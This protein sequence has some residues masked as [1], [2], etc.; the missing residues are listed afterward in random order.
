M[1]S[2]EKILSLPLKRRTVEIP[3][4]GGKIPLQE[5]TARQRDEFEIR[6]ARA[7]EAGETDANL[8]ATLVQ[9]CVM[10]GDGLMFGPEDV[11]RL[12]QCSASILDRLYDECADLSGLREKK[13]LSPQSG[14]S[15]TDSPSDS[16]EP[17]TNSS[18]P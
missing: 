6:M 11:D 15:S 8:R 3:E 13:A 1:L 10:N 16:D 2:K 14:D 12:G 9:K 17:S 4:W 7:S 5:L 18:T